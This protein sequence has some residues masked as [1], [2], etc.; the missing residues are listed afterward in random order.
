M[1]SEYSGLA[2]E[3][4]RSR[5]AVNQPPVTLEDCRRALA[6]LR[7]TSVVD[8]ATIIRCLEFLLEEHLK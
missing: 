4:A 6:M 8:R 7:D 3:F 5:A 1:V 2:D